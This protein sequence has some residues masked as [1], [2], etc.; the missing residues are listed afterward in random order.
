MGVTWRVRQK[1]GLAAT[2]LVVSTVSYTN[3]ALALVR[4]FASLSAIS[5]RAS[6][7]MQAFISGVASAYPYAVHRREKYSRITSGE[8]VANQAGL[9]GAP[10]KV[11]PSGFVPHAASVDAINAE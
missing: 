10:I 6:L 9:P 1:S 5:A 4:A 3:G 11:L 7:S 2:T 8:A